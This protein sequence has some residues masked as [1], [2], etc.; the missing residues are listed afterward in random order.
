MLIPILNVAYFYIGT[1]RSVYT[2]LNMAGFFFIFGGSLI[3][4]FMLL[5]YFL[6]DS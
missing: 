6:S 3:S 1:F 5:V 2:V 4:C